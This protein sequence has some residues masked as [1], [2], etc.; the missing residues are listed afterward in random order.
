VGEKVRIIWR[1]KSG[2]WQTEKQALKVF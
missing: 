2:D 1:D